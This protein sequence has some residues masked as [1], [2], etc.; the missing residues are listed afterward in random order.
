[1]RRSDCVQILEWVE[2]FLHCSACLFGG[3]LSAPTFPSPV[4][5]PV[6]EWMC[7]TIGNSDG[8]FR[9]ATSMLTAMALISGAGLCGDVCREGLAFDRKTIFCEAIASI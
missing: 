5:E 4:P 1:M 8:T 7:A 2:I 6:S 9:P 3:G